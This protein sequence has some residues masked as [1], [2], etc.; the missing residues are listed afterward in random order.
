MSLDKNKITAGMQIIL[1][2]RKVHRETVWHSSYV[3]QYVVIEY[4]PAFGEWREVSKWYSHS[5]SAFAALGRLTQKDVK[6][7]LDTDDDEKLAA[8]Q[9]EDER[10]DGLLPS[11]I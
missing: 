1:P 10:K 4:S 6:A 3:G 11:D 8:E 7:A 2:L 5:T 9:A